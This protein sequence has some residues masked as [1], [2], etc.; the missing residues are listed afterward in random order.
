MSKL[1]SK[2]AISQSDFEQSYQVTVDISVTEMERLARNTGF[3][4]LYQRYRERDEMLRILSKKIASDVLRE[5]LQ[6]EQGDEH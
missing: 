3:K 6:M 4:A 2:L 1:V 5:L